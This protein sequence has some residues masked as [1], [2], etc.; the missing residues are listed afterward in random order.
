[1]RFKDRSSIIT[2]SLEP[3]IELLY[4]F[5][6]VGD[7]QFVASLT[8]GDLSPRD[9]AERLLGNQELDDSP[10]KSADLN[11]TRLAE[12]AYSWAFQDQDFREQWTPDASSLEEFRVLVVAHVQSWKDWQQQ[13]AKRYFPDLRDARAQLIHQSIIPMA[14]SMFEAADA[15]IRR[16]QANW[17]PIQD[18]VVRTQKQLELMSK[19]GMPKIQSALEAFETQSKLIRAALAPAVHNFDKFSAYMKT[20][21]EARGVIT[22]LPS[23]SSIISAW[24]HAQRRIREGEEFLGEQ[25]F[26]FAISFASPS[27]LSDLAHAPDHMKGL[28][29]TNEFLRIT[30]SDDFNTLLGERVDESKVVKKRRAII[31]AA[32]AAHR[33]RNYVLSIPALFAQVEGLFTDGMILNG[34]AMIHESK[35]VALE[36]DGSLKLNK[37]G[38]P[39]K[40][41]GLGSKVQHSPFQ[42]H[43]T[44]REVS[45]AFTE[46]LT[47]Q[48]NDVLHGKSI[49]YG[50]AKLST[51]L[52]LLVFILT[53][54]ILAFE[55][56]RKARP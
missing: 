7:E 8:E 32:Y 26:H 40:L 34:L 9:L 24:E 55:Q 52:V 49:S 28:Q 48:R 19:I 10:T 1:M 3:D 33:E 42:D 25:D 21:Y 27:L 37:R 6:T 36:L 56:A 22:G 31:E 23:A 4:R 20:A 53:S 18:A 11:D 46:F 50:K 41:I 15:V 5:M 39:C 35:L 2:V 30:R 29:S 51:Q 13:F 38:N 45:S 44:L 14:S 43:D 16:L 54:E 12:A 17:R 47:S